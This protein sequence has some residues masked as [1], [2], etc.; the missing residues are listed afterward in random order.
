MTRESLK[1]NLLFSLCLSFSAELNHATWKKK[2]ATVFNI[3][4]NR[5]VRLFDFLVLV[6]SGA[7][8]GKSN[9]REK[10][11]GSRPQC[12]SCLPFIDS[13]PQC[14]FLLTVVP[15]V[16][17]PMLILA[18]WLAYRHQLLLSCVNL[19]TYLRGGTPKTSFFNS[20]RYSQGLLFNLQSGWLNI[21]SLKEEQQRRWKH[22]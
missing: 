20:P 10:I 16:F 21:L 4:K 11:R 8:N 18:G 15:N 2:Q 9:E 22:K 5:L 12:W 14:F 3:E 7:G 17:S 6:V 19:K 1:S 13:R